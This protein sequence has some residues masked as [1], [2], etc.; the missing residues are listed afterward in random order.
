MHNTADHAAIVLSLDASHVCRQVR[1]DPL[2]LFV[3][4]PK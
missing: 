3:A 4:Q 1:L 2:P